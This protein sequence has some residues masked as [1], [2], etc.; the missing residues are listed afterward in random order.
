MLLKL[1]WLEQSKQK[2]ELLSCCQSNTLA[3]YHPARG[4]YSQIFGLDQCED[5]KK[6]SLKKKQQILSARE[7][8]WNEDV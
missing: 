8:K 4:L 3:A 6:I 2:E 5:L 1:Y 7:E